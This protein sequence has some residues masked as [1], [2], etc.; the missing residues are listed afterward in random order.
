MA[1]TDPDVHT[2][3]SYCR[4]CTAIGGIVVDVA[5]DEVVRVRGDRDHPLSRGYTCP[6]GRALPAFHHHPGRLDAPRMEGSAC[7][8]TD[9]GSDLGGRL[10]GLRDDHGADAVAMYLASGS[11]FDANGRGEAER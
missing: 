11:A 6:K 3:R 8:W 5:G 7:S 10:R 2:V 9:A 1:V 4:I